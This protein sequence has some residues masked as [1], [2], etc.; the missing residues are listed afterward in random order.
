M[1]LPIL[2]VDERIAVELADLATSILAVLDD[3]RRE[4]GLE[5]APDRSIAVER[6]SLRVFAFVS[7]L[8]RFHERFGRRFG[9]LHGHRREGAANADS[10]K[11]VASCDHNERFQSRERA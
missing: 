1:D 11:E 7:P 4:P 8:D 3:Q 10:H 2:R 5:I 6:N 9:C